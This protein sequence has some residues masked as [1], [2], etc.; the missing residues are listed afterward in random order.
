[1]AAQIDKEVEKF[2]REAENRAKKILSKKKNLL[3][4]IAK[5][6]I[7]KETI[8]REE[9]ENLI[10]SKKTEKVKPLPRRGKSVKVKIKQI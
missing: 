2:I 10:S 6:L 3:A 8:E 5:T 1:M 9:F 7:E 4:K